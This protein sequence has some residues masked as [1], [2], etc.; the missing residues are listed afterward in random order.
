M[1]ESKDL[2][3]GLSNERRI[4]EFLKTAFYGQRELSS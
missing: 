2:R 3:A 4:D 1:K